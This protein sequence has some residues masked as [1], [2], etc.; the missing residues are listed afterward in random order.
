VAEAFPGLVGYAFSATMEAALDEIAGGGRGRLE[1]A[2]A[3]WR[4]FERE[5]NAAQNLKPRLPERKDLGS[6]PKCSAEDRPGHLRLIEGINQETKKPY[7]CA[8]CERTPKRSRFAAPRRRCT[9]ASSCL[10]LPARATPPPS[11]RST[12]KTEGTPGTAKLTAG[13]WQTAAGISCLP[14]PAPPC[15]SPMVHRERTDPKGEF[16]WACFADKVFLDSDK[17]GKAKQKKTRRTKT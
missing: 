14:R 12:E 4:R 15:R 13:S 5:L 2:G 3:W 6:C 17:F 8:A 10:P 7:A 16:F 9:T 11:A 1:V